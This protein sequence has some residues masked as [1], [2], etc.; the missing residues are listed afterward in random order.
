[1]SYKSNHI[2]CSNWILE[3][4]TKDG[5]KFVSIWREKKI[6]EITREM[7]DGKEF[8]SVMAECDGKRL[9]VTYCDGGHFFQV[10]KLGSDDDLFKTLSLGEA[11]RTFNE[12]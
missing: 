7:F 8:S 2:D 1:M 12:M 3:D 9:W 6:S 11:I 4:F 5:K 10:E